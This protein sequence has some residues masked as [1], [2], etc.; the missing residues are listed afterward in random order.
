[1]RVVF[2]KPSGRTY[3]VRM[4]IMGL[5]SILSDVLLGP[6]ELATRS[7]LP[8]FDFLGGLIN[9]TVITS[10]PFL[11]LAFMFRSFCFD[12]YTFNTIAYAS[13]GYRCYQQ[14]GSCFQSTPVRP[15]D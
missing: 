1:M 3:A 10:I 15:C 14:T 8:L 4:T 13:G 2:T 7:V 5:S 6:F 11:L 12:N 9:G